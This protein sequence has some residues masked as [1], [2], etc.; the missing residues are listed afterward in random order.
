MNLPQRVDR[1]I[2]L[3]LAVSMLAG[4]WSPAFAQEDMNT[5]WQRP[6]VPEYGARGPYAVGV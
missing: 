5:E 1:F 4:V 2:A 6:D 3:I